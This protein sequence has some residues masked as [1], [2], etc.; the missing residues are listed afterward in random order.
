MVHERVW[1]HPCRQARPHYQHHRAPASPALSQFSHGWATTHD[2]EVRQRNLVACVNAVSLHF[3]DR[4]GNP[5]TGHD[6]LDELSRISCPALVIGGE[7]DIFTPPW[8]PGRLP[9]PS[10]VA[11]FTSIRTPAMR[12]TGS[13]STT[14][15]R[16]YTTGCSQAD[17]PGTPRAQSS[18]GARREWFGRWDRSLPGTGPAALT[19]HLRRS[20]PFQSLPSGS[21]SGWPPALRTRSRE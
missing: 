21:P 11:N 16:V 17:P 1:P 6:V 5:C 3:K 18:F 12:S 8:M 20:S 4:D 13:A 14:S 10:P 2:L 7:A 9:A 15:T 19:D